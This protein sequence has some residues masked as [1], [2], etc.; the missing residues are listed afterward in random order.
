MKDKSQIEVALL[1]V[2]NNGEKPEGFPSHFL[3]KKEGK[4]LL[5]LKAYVINILHCVME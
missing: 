2:N 1:W 5:S 4:D 3:S